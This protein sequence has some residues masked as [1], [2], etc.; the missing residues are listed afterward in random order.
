MTLNLPVPDRTPY[1]TVPL[2]ISID[3]RRGIPALLV[4][5]WDKK[6]PSGLWGHDW[7]LEIFS[8]ETKNPGTA[9]GRGVWSLLRPYSTRTN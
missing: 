3:P 1:L 9:G 8:H 7:D 6:R 2:L 5:P 4:G